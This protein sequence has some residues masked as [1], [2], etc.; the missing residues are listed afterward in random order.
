MKEILDNIS[1]IH[2][3]VAV[4][5]S[6]AIHFSSFTET[7]CHFNYQCDNLNI[8]IPFPTG[9]MKLFKDCQ[10]RP[11]VLQRSLK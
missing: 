6:T 11:L 5:S 9:K 8:G 2:L 3:L 1:D 10:P 7:L 4:F